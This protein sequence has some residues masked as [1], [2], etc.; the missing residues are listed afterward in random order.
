M[1]P[2]EWYNSVRGQISDGAIGLISKPALISNII[3]RHDR[4]PD[5]SLGEWSHSF[6]VDIKEWNGRKRLMIID[7][8][9]GGVKPSFL[10]DL[11]KKSNNVIFLIPTCSQDK[12][13][14][15][16]F[17]SYERAEKGIKYDYSNGI[18]E[19]LN[20]RYGWKLKITQRDLHDI[21]TDWTAPQFIAQDM[22]KDEFKLLPLAFP[23]DYD[24]YSNE[25]VKK[26]RY[27]K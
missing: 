6:S 25:S 3:R 5:G 27:K 11:I 23:N 26:L 21:C 17:D 8:N 18:K 2:E 13:Q 10:S 7:S 14:K 19:A 24:R 9:P 16:L 1:T 15:A 20:R 4:K 22:A 12:I